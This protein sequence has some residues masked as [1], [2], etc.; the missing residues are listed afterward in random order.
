MKSGINKDIHI[1]RTAAIE[2]IAADKNDFVRIAGVVQ[3]IKNWWK[4]KFNSEFREQYNNIEEAYVDMKGPLSDLIN[5]L[6]E[7]DKAFGSQDPDSVARLVGEIPSVITNVT[8]DMKDLNTKMRIA[9]SLI[10]TS[11]VDEEGNELS[12]KDDNVRQ[13]Q[14]GYKKN[15]ELV[16]KLY[17]LLPYEYK[18]EIPVGQVINKPISSFAWFKQFGPADII[19]S[20]SVRDVTRKLLVE[21]LVRTGIDQKAIE[22]FVVTDENY[23]RFLENLATAVLN[24]GILIQVNF[25]SVSKDI[26]NRRA[27]EMVT[28][29]NVGDVSLPFSGGELLINVARVLLH[30]LKASVN[31]VQQLSVFIIRHLKLS[32]YSY[33]KLLEAKKRID[34]GQEVNFQTSLANFPITH[35]V[36]KA[37]NRKQGDHG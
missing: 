2:L 14:K 32:T 30:D 25:P 11:Y 31:S 22:T 9:D 23:N 21:S 29:V 12:S 18:A 20:P 24:Q 8:K 19:F 36:K 13:V 33:A 28:E 34:E 7:L 16:D 37:I 6:R 5:K 26:S 10:P 3:K 1:L 15:K 4:A 27:N 35:L 17:S